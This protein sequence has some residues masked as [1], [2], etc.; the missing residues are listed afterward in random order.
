MY[1]IV[2]IIG[3]LAFGILIG[4]ALGYSAGYESMLKRWKVWW[5][6]NERGVK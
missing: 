3:V 4:Y 2:T 6:N 5:R 1:D